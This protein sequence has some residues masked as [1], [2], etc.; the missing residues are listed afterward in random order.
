MTV[1]LRETSAT[2][3]ALFHE[4]GVDAITMDDIA[5]ATGVSRRTLFRWC[6]SKYALVWV[7]AGMVDDRIARAFAER[8]DLDDVR[9]RLI[10]AYASSVRPIRESVATSRIRLR[11][12]DDHP[13]VYAA[14]HEFREGVRATMRGLAAAEGF[15]ELEATALAAAVS[16]AGYASLV[17]WAR[18]ADDDVHPDVAIERGL[19]AALLGR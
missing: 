2:A 4:H 10:V 18:E 17:W 7:G 9:E 1:D 5:E 11:L 12:I 3:L 14:G 15:D 8:L 16:F 19:R 6:P 13:A